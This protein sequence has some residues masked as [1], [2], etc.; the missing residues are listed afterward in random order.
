MTYSNS[1]LDVRGDPA[2]DADTGI[3]KKEFLPLRDK[4]NIP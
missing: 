2:D 4:G 3:F 1:W